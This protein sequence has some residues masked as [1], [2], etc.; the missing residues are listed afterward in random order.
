MCCKSKYF[1]IKI[2]SGKVDTLFT[3]FTPTAVADDYIAS[4]DIISLNL[5]EISLINE[6]LADFKDPVKWE[7]LSFTGTITMNGIPAPPAG[8]ENVLTGQVEIF[9]ELELE[10]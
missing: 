10:P 7:T 2:T 9:L 5:S 4:P 3:R 1:G 6:Y 8:E